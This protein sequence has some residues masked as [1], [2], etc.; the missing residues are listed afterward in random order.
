MF[1]WTRDEIEKILIQLD[2]KG[3]LFKKYS[4]TKK[5]KKL[6]LLGQ[7]GFALVYEAESKSN[8]KEE[9]VIKVIGFGD[10]NVDSLFF[11]NSVEA[12]YDLCL[13]N[14]HIVKVY[15]SLEIFVWLNADN[16]VTAVQEHD[17]E[18]NDTEC[19][20]LQ[21]I[22]MEKIDSVLSGGKTTKRKI[23]PDSLARFDE[24]EV[25]KVAYDIGSA[26]ALAHKK[27]ILHRDVKLENIFYDSKKKIYKLGDFGIARTTDD[28]MASTVTF[29]K[30]YGAPE[31]VS[32]IEEKYDNT[33]DIYSLGILLFVLLNRLKFPESNSYVV[34][35]KVQYTKGYTLPEPETGS[36]KLTGI[37]NKMCRYDPDER[38]QSMDDVLNDLEKLI[39]ESDVYYKKEHKVASFAIGTIFLW[40]GLIVWKLSFGS[41]YILDFSIMTYVLVLLAA[42]K[43]MLHVFKRETTI[44]SIAILGVGLYL[45][46]STGF[47]WIKL[48]VLGCILLSSGY[49]AGAF[50]G[51]ML[52]LNF[53]NII[54]KQGLLRQQDFGDYRWLAVTLLLLAL[55]FLLHNS[56]LGL[57]EHKVITLYFNKNRFWMVM[58]AVY[59]MIFVNGLQ[60]KNDGMLSYFV[61]VFGEG[62][63]EIIVELEPIKVG[64]VGLGVCLIWI[65]REKILSRRE[66]NSN[67]N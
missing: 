36:D 33:A 6:H 48:L 31:V 8:T 10:K 5:D 13:K 4:F 52:I 28:G 2:E 32:S 26:L 55:T 29:T 17:V 49:V 35:A 67:N 11:Q 66:I 44:C 47:T 21:F 43:F 3:F 53:A 62:M 60:F 39:Y 63:I 40:M 56:V 46:Y 59:M 7:G 38:Y 64:L 1:I 30:G 54:E 25:I 41:T 16:C 18:L 42:I 50:S 9:Y 37:V 22:V 45:L 20:K 51:G 19:L 58:C 57:E 34:N 24:R 61:K 65:V 23:T 14:E 12:Q 27:N 15:D